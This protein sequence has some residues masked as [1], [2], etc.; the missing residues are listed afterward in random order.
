MKRR[1]HHQFGKD[2]TEEEQNL[3][4][5][6]R[7]IRRYSIKPYSELK[8]EK[9][10]EEYI[11]RLENK[12][13]EPIT[14]EQFM[15][16]INIIEE[17]DENNVPVRLQQAR[18]IKEW[19]EKNET[20][21]PPR[22]GGKDIPKEEGRLGDA[23]NGIRQRLIKPYEKL[24][25][26]EERE[27]YINKLENKP[28]E[29]MTREQFMEILGI[30]EEIDRNNIPILLQ[31]ARKIKEWM[32]KNETTRPPSIRKRCNRRREKIRESIKQN[33]NK[34]NKPI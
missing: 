22:K 12:K 13:K 17:I 16:I 31:N 18:K 28:L 27:E 23:L 10:R 2:A 30:V 11:N 6:L 3:A 15:E 25:N 24:K 8:T 7:N 29:P 33:K 20:T 32:N 21:R 34:F 5:K 19:M 26:E 14:R 9:E 1:D 4:I